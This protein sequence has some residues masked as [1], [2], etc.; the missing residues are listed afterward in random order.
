MSYLARVA[1]QF[2][3]EPGS[4]TALAKILGQ[5]QTSSASLRQKSALV[6]SR[7]RERLVLTTNALDAICPQ[8]KRMRAVLRRLRVARALPIHRMSRGRPIAAAAIGVMGK[9]PPD[10]RR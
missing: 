6:D 9:L 7:G 4:Y 8:R 1:V 3:S 5:T 2:T 10:R